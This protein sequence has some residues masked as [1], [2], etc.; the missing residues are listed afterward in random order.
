MNSGNTL[1]KA[2][3]EWVSGNPVRFIDEEGWPSN[4]PCSNLKIMQ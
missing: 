1:S 3:H 4:K 2:M